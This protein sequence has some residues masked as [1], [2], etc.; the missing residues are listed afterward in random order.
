MTVNLHL[1]SLADGGMRASRN[2]AARQIRM[3]LSLADGGMRASRN[4]VHRRPPSV[5]SLADGGM[6]ASR[7]AGSGATVIDEV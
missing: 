5:R 7:N 2:S 1:S 6:R 3:L 4:R